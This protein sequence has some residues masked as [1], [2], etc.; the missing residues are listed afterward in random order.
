MLNGEEAERAYSAALLAFRREGDSPASRER[1]REALEANPYVPAY[2]SGRRRLPRFPPEH[3]G[4]GDKNEAVAYVFDA[5]EAWRKTRGAIPW[6][7][8]GGKGKR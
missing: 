6:L 1:R 4:I 7:L 2:L 3:V 5:R 8:K